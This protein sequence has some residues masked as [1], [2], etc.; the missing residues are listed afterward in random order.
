MHK[1][2][3]ITG[4]DS[5][6]GLSVA[7]ALLQRDAWHVHIIG[8]N[9]TKGERALSILGNNAYF[10]R[11]DVTNYQ[12]LAEVFGR[13]FAREQRLDFVF[14]NAGVVGRPQFESMHSQVPPCLEQ[15]PPALDQYVCDVNFKGVVSTVHLAQYYFAKNLTE[16]QSLVITGS[17]ASIWPASLYPLYTASKVTQPFSSILNNDANF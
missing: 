10:Y 5:G 16:D 13:I 8:T 2:A 1:V 7:T 14:A 3:I 17:C 6:I 12:G 11:E 9:P 4:G 15:Q